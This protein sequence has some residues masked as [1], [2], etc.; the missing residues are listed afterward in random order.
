MGK[1]GNK[2]VERANSRPPM[3]SHAQVEGSSSSSSSSSDDED[4]QVGDFGPSAGA[5][6]ERAIPA[7]FDQPTETHP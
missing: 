3:R 2:S 4:V 5:G 1:Y 6:Y 7:R